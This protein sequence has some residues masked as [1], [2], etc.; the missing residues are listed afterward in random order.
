[1]IH[2]LGIMP[3]SH[4]KGLGKQ[5]VQEAIFAARKSNQKAIRLDVLSGN[6]PAMKLYEH[7]GFIY[8]QTLQLFYED[9]GLTDFLLY[10]LIL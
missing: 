10:E 3:T 1:M 6:L 4:G 5:L 7:M 9:T 8:K 2:A